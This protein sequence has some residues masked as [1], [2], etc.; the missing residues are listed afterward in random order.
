MKNVTE[1]ESPGVGRERFFG[2]E[3]WV[4]IRGIIGGVVWK[5]KE[6]GKRR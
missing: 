3:F 4:V 6:G 2:V 5:G 1:F